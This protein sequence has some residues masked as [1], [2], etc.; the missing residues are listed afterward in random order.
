VCEHRFT[1]SLGGQ[2]RNL[3]ATRGGGVFRIG[4]FS[5]I[6]RV[7]CRLLRYYDGI[8]LLKPASIDRDSGYRY[9]SAAQLPMLNRILVL[10]EL[11]LSL[12]EIVRVVQSSASPAQLRALLNA[13]RSEIERSLAAEQ[14]RLRQLETRIAQL[15]SGGELIADDVIVRSDPAQW[16]LSTRQLLPSFAAAREVISAVVRL[17][18]KSIASD[19]LG[20]LLAIAHASEFEPDQLD[21]EVGFIVRSQS[22]DSVSDTGGTTLTLRELPATQRLA[23]CVR[24]GLPE[25]AHLITGKIG[26]FVEANG[27]QLAGPS[28]ELF[29][30]SPRLDRMA[31]SVV[32]MQFPIEKN[33]ENGVTTKNT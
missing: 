9:Y 23:T 18:K 7:S 5:R 1:R 13:R 30:Q 15:D 16:L 4:D 24:I 17:A 31:E 6:A 26:A 20:P 12:D 28:R 2:A 22:Q 21:V 25:H 10:K 14:E 19:R 11:G 29:L 3:S 32:E 27:Y 33:Q 8:G